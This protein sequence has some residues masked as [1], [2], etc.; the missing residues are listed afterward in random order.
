MKVLI[1]IFWSHMWK[2]C[3]SS[4]LFYGYNAEMAFIFYSLIACYCKVQFKYFQI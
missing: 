3:D 1:E 2:F 4:N